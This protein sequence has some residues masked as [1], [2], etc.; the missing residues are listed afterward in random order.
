MKRR[1]IKEEK[2]LWK[3]IKE[4]RKRDSDVNVRVK[5]RV[6]ERTRY[7]ILKKLITIAMNLFKFGFRP[8]D[9]N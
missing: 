8:L 5:E 4:K 2:E 3:R 7:R 1:N 6:R 9:L